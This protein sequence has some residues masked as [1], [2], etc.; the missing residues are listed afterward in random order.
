MR[1]RLLTT[2]A[3]S[4]KFGPLVVLHIEVNVA[5]LYCTSHLPQGQRAEENNDMEEAPVPGE[6]LGKR[7]ILVKCKSLMLKLTARNSAGQLTHVR[8]HRE[9]VKKLVQVASFTP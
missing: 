9:E 5:P 6:H 3:V 8:K 4:A 2:T 1:L 7:R